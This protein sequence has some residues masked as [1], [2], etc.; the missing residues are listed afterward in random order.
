M[1]FFLLLL[2]TQY[3]SWKYIERYRAIQILMSLFLCKMSSFVCVFICSISSCSLSPFLLVVDTSPI[4]MISLTSLS[5]SYVDTEEKQNLYTWTPAVVPAKLMNC[6]FLTCQWRFQSRC[7]H[8]YNLWISLLFL[9]CWK[10]KA[11]AG[12]Y[13]IFRGAHLFLTCQWRF[14][15]WCWHLCN[16]LRCTT[17]YFKPI[18]ISKPMLAL[19]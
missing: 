15:S 6:N 16:L 14:Q 9:S 5:L 1:L 18:D 17:F 10:T 7:W 2:L 19:M 12:T 4:P 11:N 3:S 8:L 13:V